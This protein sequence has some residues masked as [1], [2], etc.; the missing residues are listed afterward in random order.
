MYVPNVFFLLTTY[1]DRV[2]LTL[3]IHGVDGLERFD[4][5]VCTWLCQLHINRCQM[6]QLPSSIALLTDLVELDLSYNRF[7]SIDAIDFVRMSKLTSL[8]VRVHLLCYS[9]L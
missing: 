2:V 9:R 7:A 4:L 3:Q 1:I 5:S 6:R 8:N